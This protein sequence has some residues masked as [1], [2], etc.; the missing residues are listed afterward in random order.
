[1]AAGDLIVGPTY[2]QYEY[3]GFL[4]G[5]ATDIMVEKVK[6]LLDN[7]DLK[8]TDEE[9]AVGAGWGD[10]PGL[11]DY[12]ARYVTFNVVV[13]AS[14]IAAMENYVEQ[15]P[16]IFIARSIPLQFV[17]QRTGK[18]KRFLWAKP[19]KT[20]FDSD[21]DLAKRKWTGSVML[22]CDDP[23]KYSLQEFIDPLIIPNGATTVN[24][25][26]V[27][28]GS[29]D[30]FPILE[31]LGP[32]TNPRVQ[33]MQ[34]QG[35][36]LRV[37]LTVNA[38]QTLMIDVRSQTVAL[39]GADY[40]NYLSNDSNWWFLKPGVNQLAYTRDDAGGASTCN[41]HHRDTWV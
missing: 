36:F 4:F 27:N 9:R 10:F 14:S 6:G 32:C 26:V 35:H 37:N 2:P 13:L 11:Q 1:M 29:T 17:W 12:K 33:N 22:K 34:D 5:S 3:N 39:N 18:S 20:D 16:A 23:R 38:G 7:P 41:V 24:G 31:I 25:N 30:A 15:I 8:T 19:S 21:Y 28:N 40:S